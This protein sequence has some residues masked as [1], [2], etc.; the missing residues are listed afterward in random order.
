MQGY[1]ILFVKNIFDTTKWIADAL[2]ERYVDK[3]IWA[4]DLG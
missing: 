4:T 3:A 1:R 2:A